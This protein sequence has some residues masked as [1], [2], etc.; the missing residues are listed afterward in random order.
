MWVAVRFRPESKSLWPG[1]DTA[2]KISLSADDDYRWRL[3]QTIIGEMGEYANSA[4]KPIEIVNISYP[5]QIY[6]DVWESSFDGVPDIYDRH[7]G[8][9]RL[10]EICLWHGIVYVD[11]TQEFIEV[12]RSG[13]RW[14]HNR[15]DAHPTADGHELIVRVVHAARVN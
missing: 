2:L 14:L 10:G 6:D 4:G 13:Q 15:S 12:A 8:S 7:I 11:T 3:A 5:A 1:L 9:R